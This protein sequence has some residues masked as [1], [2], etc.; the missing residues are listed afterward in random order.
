VGAAI[1]MPPERKAE[2]GALARNRFLEIDSAFR[3][4]V[5]SLLAR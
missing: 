3:A 4:R 2:M 5:G 1:G